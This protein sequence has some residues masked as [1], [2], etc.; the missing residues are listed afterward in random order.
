MKVIL[1]E[2][3]K[4][5]GKKGEIIEVSDGYGRNVLIKKN[6]AIEATP[7]NLNSLKLE[8]LNNEKIEKEKYETALKISEVLKNSK[9]TIGLKV[10]KNNQTFGTISNKDIADEIRKQLN[11]NIDKKQIVLKNNIKTLGDNNITIKLH[12]D[13]T[14]ILLINVIAI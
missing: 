2:D 12:K 14:V 7:E 3:I 13:V 4:G 5:K 1:K 11:L 10:G 6:Q 8:K 9:I